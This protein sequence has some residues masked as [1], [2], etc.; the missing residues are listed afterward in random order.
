MTPP[1]FK[2]VKQQKTAKHVSSPSRVT[3]V[4]SSTDVYMDQEELEDRGYAQLDLQRC[5]LKHMRFRSQWAFYM[6]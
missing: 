2:I 4:E 6:R 3:A 5:V 1:R